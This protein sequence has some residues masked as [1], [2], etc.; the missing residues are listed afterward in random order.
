MTCPFLWAFRK[1]TLEASVDVLYLL[2]CERT[3]VL[4]VG[5]R[6]ILTVYKRC[7]QAILFKTSFVG[8]GTEAE[9]GR[10]SLRVTQGDTVG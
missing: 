6:V 10:G 3:C 9:R 5:I 2:I 4:V 7:H 1:L 8:W